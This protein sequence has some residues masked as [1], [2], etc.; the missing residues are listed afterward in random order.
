VKQLNSYGIAI[1]IALTIMLVGCTQQSP[2]P[3]PTLPLTPTSTFE[4]TE[5]PTIAAT[6]EP[7]P[8]GQPTVAAT[9]TPTP[10]KAPTST[11]TETPTPTPTLKGPVLEAFECDGCDEE[12]GINFSAKG[13]T[14][15]VRINLT[16]HGPGMIRSITY[17]FVCYKNENIQIPYF[18]PSIS[19]WGAVSPTEGTFIV[20]SLSIDAKQYTHLQHID[21]KEGDILPLFIKRFPGGVNRHYDC[22]LY[23]TN[24]VN[25]LKDKINLNQSFSIAFSPP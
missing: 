13:G 23:I 2:Q 6:I 11:P 18:A 22:T 5:V 25:F 19:H 1:I 15:T 3:N 16:N 9:E 12:E 21:L 10:T 4:P 7:S 17:G 24:Q 14:P 8:T 20:G